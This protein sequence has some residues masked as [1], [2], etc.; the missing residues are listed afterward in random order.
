MPF[1]T[2]VQLTSGIQLFVQK[3]LPNRV[4]PTITLTTSA[5]V[6]IGATSIPV[7]AV[8]APV[9]LGL[10]VGS[11]LIQQ[12]DSFTFNSTVPTKVKVSKDVIAGDLFVEVEPTLTAIQSGNIATSNG[13]L[14]LLGANDAGFKIGDKLVPT[15]SFESGIYDENVKVMLSAE[16]SVSGFYR[17]GDP[18]IKQVIAPA[19]QTLDTEI[20]FKLV[21]PNKEFRSGFGLVQGFEDGNKLDDIRNYKFTLKCNG[22]FQTGTLA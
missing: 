15:R 16:I 9:G 3:S 13:F 12:G 8:V 11:V 19:S 4:L 21:Y 2:A 18:C 1:P 10:P 7:T 5:L 6:A 20:A 17:I 14:Q 22:I